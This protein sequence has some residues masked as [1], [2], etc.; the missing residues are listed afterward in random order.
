M[1]RYRAKRIIIRE[2]PEISI[3]F[4]DWSTIYVFPKGNGQGWLFHKWYAPRGTYLSA[5]K[6]FKKKLMSTKN[7]NLAKCCQL[8]D[9]YGVLGKSPVGKLDLS[10]KSVEIR[11]L[12]W[13]IAGIIGKG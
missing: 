7:L 10:D 5:W 2:L 6:P 3:I 8:A 12:K 4:W 9:K 11:F 13:K 1:G